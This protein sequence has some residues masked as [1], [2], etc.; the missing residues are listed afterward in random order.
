MEP[1]SS[2]ADEIILPLVYRSDSCSLL[3]HVVFKDALHLTLSRPGEHE[4]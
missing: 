4:D 1:C 3:V 2:D